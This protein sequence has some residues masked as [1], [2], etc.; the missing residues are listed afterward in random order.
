M[1]A[2]QAVADID[3]MLDQIELYSIKNELSR[4]KLGA[5][6]RHV[7]GWRGKHYDGMEYPKSRSQGLA[8]L[9][10]VMMTRRIRKR[11]TRPSIKK[12]EQ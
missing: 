4:N 12:N 2:I 8:D 1:L 11:R 5:A 3:E 10:Y 9:V 7:N 6:I